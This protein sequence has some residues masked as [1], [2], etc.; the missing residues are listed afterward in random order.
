MALVD[1]TALCHRF[2]DSSCKMNTNLPIVDNSHAHHI[3]GD[4]G[5]TRFSSIFAVRVA[6][7][8]EPHGWSLDLMRP[9]IKIK[10]NNQLLLGWGGLQ[11]RDARCECR[12]AL[13]G[14]GGVI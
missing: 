1:W 3:I 6:L 5:Y 4:V 14:G 12:V 2:G 7:G 11:R 9:Q 13:R 10:N 8:A